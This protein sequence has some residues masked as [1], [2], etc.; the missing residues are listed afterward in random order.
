LV[1]RA[2]QLERVVGVAV[3]RAVVARSQPPQDHMP[4]ARS[5]QVRLLRAR[6]LL[7]L[8]HP[9]RLL[10]ALWL[11]SAQLPMQLPQLAVLELS[12]PNYD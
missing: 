11:I 4:R 10:L 7:V 5:H 1:G 3:R 6:S 9:V 12:Q 8:W 2:Y